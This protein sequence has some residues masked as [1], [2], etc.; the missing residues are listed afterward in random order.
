MKKPL[1]K[2]SRFLN[3]GIIVAALWAGALFRASHHLSL[4][5]RQAPPERTIRITDISF[6][7]GDQNLSAGDE[8]FRSDLGVSPDERGER[9]DSRPSSGKGASRGKYSSKTDGSTDLKQM[10]K[11][12]HP[13][14]RPPGDMKEYLDEAEKARGVR[15]RKSLKEIQRKVKEWEKS[16]FEPTW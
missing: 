10:S 6:S 16:I 13:I 14:D 1:W 7:S 5:S 2:R 8:L 4:L 11:G 3:I 12:I 15:I 9:K